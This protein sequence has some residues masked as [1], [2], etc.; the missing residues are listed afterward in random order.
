MFCS[1]KFN[2][3]ISSFKYKFVVSGGS[4]TKWESDPNRVFNL[5]NL[6]SIISSSDSGKYENCIYSKSGN[7]VSLK[8]SWR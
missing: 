3:K 8:C 5:A 4:T 7:L 6:S 2:L 1:K